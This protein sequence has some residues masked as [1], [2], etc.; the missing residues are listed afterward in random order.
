MRPIMLFL[1]IAH[2][3]LGWALLA[4]IDT[5]IN[6]INESNH[7]PFDP[8]WGL[9]CGVPA[10]VVFIYLVIVFRGRKPQSKI[11]LETPPD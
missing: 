1:S 7:L 8:L 11:F 3:A 2:A 4:V 10:L 6:A 5:I 9:L